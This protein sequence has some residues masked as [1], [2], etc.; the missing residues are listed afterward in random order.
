MTVIASGRSVEADSWQLSVHT[1]PETGVLST[2][3]NVQLADG[4]AVWGGGCGDWVPPDKRLNSYAGASDTGPRTFLARVTPDVRA[5]VIT[6]SD[7]TREDLV[8]HAV[9]DAAGLRAGVLV[10]P[11]AL[12]IHRVD[13]IG[14][15]GESL[16]L[17]G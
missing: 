5:V 7:G 11:R 9:G 17:E 4:S 13:L 14:T 12:D 2:M 1:D 8:L 10:Y 16:P 15:H 3:V 6:L